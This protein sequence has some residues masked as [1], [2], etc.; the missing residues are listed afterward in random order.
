[1]SAAGDSAG[2]PGT[3]TVEIE[4]I[5]VGG[6]GVGRWDGVAVFVPRS[7][8]GDRLRVRLTKAGKGGRFLRGSIDAV[9]RPSPQRVEPPCVHYTRDGCGGCRLQHLDYQ[10][11]LTAKS[12]I[13]RD[14]LQRIGKRTV[15]PPA[16]SASP[17]P[18]RYRRKLTMAMQRTPDANPRAGAGA[19]GAG[20]A[21]SRVGGGWIAGLHPHDDPVAVFPVGDCL[22]TDERVLT[23]W[24]EVLA[25]G[26]FLPAGDDLRGAVRLDGEPA[27]GGAAFVLEGAE[28]G[29]EWSTSE[30]FFAAVPS[31]AELWWRRRRGGSA[32]LLHSRGASPMAGT[33]AS[34]VQVNSAVARAMHGYVINQVLAFAPA[35]VVDAYAGD[36][37][38]AAELGRRGARVT[39]IELD[40]AASARSASRLSPGSRAVAARVEDALPGALPADVVVLNPPRAGVDARVTATLTR[41]TPAPRAIVY[42]SCDPATLARDLA[43]LP[44]YRIA[45]LA[46]F[47]MFPQTAHVETVCTLVP[48]DS[49]AVSAP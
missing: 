30:R 40:A 28:R 19:S 34:F 31:L 2:T 7:A 43:R 8:P 1:M 5:A 10:W 46:A 36:G 33:G 18:W 17:S 12:G 3:A 45:A 24:R 47:D 14:A 15:E 41:I 13:V 11:Q 9:E 35:T 27:D 22:I 26:A 6:D 20:H 37:D 44:S 16:V 23:V 32:T 42:V 25:A 38:T 29:S 21:E 48:D 49:T 4:R 39:A